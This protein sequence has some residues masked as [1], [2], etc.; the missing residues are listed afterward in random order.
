MNF[1]LIGGGDR[2]AGNQVV[3]EEGLVVEVALQ[4]LI[5]EWQTD[6]PIVTSVREPLK[7]EP[8]YQ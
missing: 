7:I 5:K 3:L 2:P 1:K 4:H 8:R 6:Y